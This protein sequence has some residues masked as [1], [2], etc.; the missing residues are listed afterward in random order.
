[1]EG[2]GKG[3][4]AGGWRGGGRGGG[5]GGAGGGGGGGGGGW[6]RQMPDHIYIYI[7][8]YIYVYR[9]M[10][11]YTDIHMFVHTN[12][13]WLGRALCVIVVSVALGPSPSQLQILLQAGHGG[14]PSGT[15]RGPLKA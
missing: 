15:A 2:G 7:H 10:F 14:L 8:I 1:M 12:V 4:G 5:G 6:E 3:G 9:H 13:G 11:T